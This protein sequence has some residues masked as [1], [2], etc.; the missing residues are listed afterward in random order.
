MMKK[1]MMGLTLAALIGVA[2]QAFAFGHT[3]ILQENFKS[4]KAVGVIPYADGL[5]EAYLQT[6]VN[7]LLK[8]RAE[9]LAK[10]AGG[11][12]T[13]SYEITVNRPTLFS[14][15][16]K[17]AGNQTLYD[18]VNVDVA[19]GAELK[20]ED[21]LYVKS[22]EYLHYVGTKKF[23]FAENGIRIQNTA[24]GPFDTVVPYNQIAPMINVAEGARLL[25]SYKLTKESKDKT[26]ELKAGELVALFLDSNPATGL[27]W[28][29]TDRS[30]APGF[31]N[32]GHSFYLPMENKT[33]RGGTPGQTIM[34]FAFDKPG[35]YTVEAVYKRKMEKS[36]YDELNFHFNVK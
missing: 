20:P 34:F 31:K 11:S 14:V 33:S 32:L 27:D 18:G 15:L 10:K 2:G 22:D 21:L 36:P 3:T 17:A 6:N 25:T 12:P 30:A 7:S 8:D 24:D 1:W 9:A 28:V 29:L 35:T 26:L 5:K 19:A 23:I 16:L 4:G 13:V